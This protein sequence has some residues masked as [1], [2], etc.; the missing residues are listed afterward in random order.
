MHHI[1]MIVANAYTHDV[2][3]I[4]EAETL[5]K[6]GYRVSVIGW[7][8]DMNMM[9]EEFINGVNV[10]RLRLPM[11]LGS[12]NLLRFT[13]I[14]RFW[15]YAFFK[16]RAL[17]PDIIHTHDFSGLPPAVFVSI[18]DRNWLIY[19]S[20]E[21]FPDTLG[22]RLPKLL[23]RLGDLI[24]RMFWRRANVVFTVGE[25]LKT[26]L[27]K[28]G[29]RRVELLGNWKDRTDFEFSDLV[30][31]AKRQ[32]LGLHKYRLV[33][34]YLGVLSPQRTTPELLEAV[35]QCADVGLLIAGYGPSEALVKSMTQYPNIHFLGKVN[36]K[37]I[38]FYTALSD[39]V[40]YGLSIDYAGGYF[41]TPN[42]LHEALAAGKAMLVTRGIGEIGEIVESGQC[43]VLMPVPTTAEILKSFEIL[44]D[45]SQLA[46]L[47]SNAN[48]LYL[49][50]YS[51]Q[52]AEEMLLG[53]YR[54]LL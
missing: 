52:R 11:K 6:A 12:I 20:H 27:I 29:A 13:K 19:D 50:H 39:V 18:L 4:N 31:E 1:V 10:Y 42:K 3:V 21:S 35:T 46:I 54:E 36:N 8:R 33:I 25:R 9:T 34:A 26:S 24:E 43:G 53:I 17:H 30:L 44:K 23:I 7:D 15:S 2:R 45:R 41:S 22:N 16:A 48:Q 37:E 51:W 49:R 38:P 47:Q 14:G 40:Y 5:V 32:E 28:R